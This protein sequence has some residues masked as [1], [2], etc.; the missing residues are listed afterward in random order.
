MGSLEADLLSK[1][2]QLT[3]SVTFL[4]IGKVSGNRASLPERKFNQVDEATLFNQV[5]AR[6]RSFNQIHER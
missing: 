5:V 2:T 4:E 3:L 1:R 6:N